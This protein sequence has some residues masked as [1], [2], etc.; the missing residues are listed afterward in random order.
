MTIR[1][2]AIKLKYKHK[3]HLP[4]YICN[5]NPVSKI[6][7]DYRA[8]RS[9]RYGTHTR[10]YDYM[11]EKNQ[12]YLRILLIQKWLKKMILRKRLI[13]LTRALIPLYYHPDR[14]GGYFDIKNIT[15]YFD[16]F[17]L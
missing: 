7:Y 16:S 5:F 2:T 11:D 14:K 10:I 3:H 12:R 6:I 17:N 15:D 4:S 8:Y 9:E 13:R 1:C